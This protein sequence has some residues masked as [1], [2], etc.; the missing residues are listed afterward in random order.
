MTKEKNMIFGIL[1][2]IR[3]YQNPIVLFIFC[4]IVFSSCIPQKKTILMQYHDVIDSTYATTFE[5]TNFEDTIY[6]IQ[7]NDYLYINIT[8]VDKEI[9][10]FFQPLAG[11]NY[12]N[13]QNQALAGYN[14]NDD[15][16]ID[17]PYVG[18]IHL[19][20]QTIREAVITIKKAAGKFI[21]RA[22]I[23]VKLINNTVNI[24]GEV[25][26]EGCFNMTKSKLSIYEAITL[27]GGFTDY[28]KRNKV[29]VLRT[30]NKKYKLFI[31]DMTSGNLIG[32][33]MFY[34]YPNDV[35]YVEPMRAK[36]LGITPTFS[37][38]ILTTI[39][40]FYILLQSIN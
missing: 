1:K 13:D 35:I 4:L 24:L 6:R 26:D 38:T 39:I 3:F 28:A 27:A 12:I 19:E 20:G 31:V 33:N 2:K 32:K 18:K 40:T 29:K 9:T 8:S 34:V 22:R 25:K 21:G 11:V 16:A 30:V 15:G 5:G 17:F 23:D 36:A 14:V 10:Y 7:P 37:L